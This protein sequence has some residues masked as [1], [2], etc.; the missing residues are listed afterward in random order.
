MNDVSEGSKLMLMIILF[1]EATNT[2]AEIEQGLRLVCLQ[3]NCKNMKCC[4]KMENDVVDDMNYSKS[5]L[6]VLLSPRASWRPQPEQTRERQ[7]HRDHCP[8][9]S[10]GSGRD[11]AQQPRAEHWSDDP[12]QQP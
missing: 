6:C 2:R 1:S 7:Q 4:Y 9:R 10:K 12:R 3:L 8:G 5:L 11:F